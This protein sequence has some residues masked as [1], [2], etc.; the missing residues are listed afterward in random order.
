[1]YSTRAEQQHFHFAGWHLHFQQRVCNKRRDVRARVCDAWRVHFICRGLC[2]CAS[3][4]LM[5]MMR[6]RMAAV[7][8]PL[9]ILECKCQLIILYKQLRH[10]FWISFYY[11]LRL[12]CLSNRPSLAIFGAGGFLFFRLHFR[13]YL[14]RAPISSSICP[15]SPFG[16]VNVRFL[17]TRT[18]AKKQN[19]ETSASVQS[20]CTMATLRSYATR[21]GLQISNSKAR[22][23]N[24][25]FD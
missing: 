18:H 14:P 16:K 9:P 23:S 24:W 11:Y 19:I 25:K 20:A 2:V 7:L 17:T 12:D 21:R 1:M 6:W 8:G 3:F 22:R 4:P 5:M 13:F 15:H 10:T